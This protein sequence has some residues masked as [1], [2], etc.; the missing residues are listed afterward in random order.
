MFPLFPYERYGI[1]FPGLDLMKRTSLATGDDRFAAVAWQQ[2][3]IQA[4]K[5]GD[6][7]LAQQLNTAKMDNSPFRFPT[8]WP[9]DIDWA[10]DHNWGGSGMIGLQEMV[11]QT[12]S[13][14]GQP[15]KIRIL[16]AWPSAWDVDFKLHAPQQTVIEG[17]LVSGHLEKLT[18]T[19]EPRM[20]DVQI[21]RAKPRPL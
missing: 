9:H 10:P 12:H 7:A 3:N 19:P 1:G 17:T 4:A 11:M 21:L 16:P 2:A 8:F 18:V 5:L 20:R 14:P 13:L 15:G 6:T